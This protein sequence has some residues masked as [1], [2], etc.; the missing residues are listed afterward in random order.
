MRMTVLVATMAMA[1]FVPPVVAGEQGLGM[2][3]SDVVDRFN[4]A[5]K[6]H[7]W[8]VR[9]VQE[10]CSKSSGQ[11]AC[12]YYISDGLIAIG[13]ALSDDKTLKNLSV[14][15]NTDGD[16]GKLVRSIGTIISMMDPKVDE[17]EAKAVINA[18]FRGVGS[19]KNDEA[20]ADLHGTRIRALIPGKLGVFAVIFDHP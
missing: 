17:A 19:S 13:N 1:L 12:N 4:D 6:S 3:I 11:T 20:K 5:A 9:L 14:F 16:R 18:L 7:D 10:S 15:Y 8:E 2:Q